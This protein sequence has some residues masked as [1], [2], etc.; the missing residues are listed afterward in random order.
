MILTVDNLSYKV[1][2]DNEVELVHFYQHRNEQEELIVPEIAARRRVVSISSKAFYECENLRR[3]VLPPTVKRIR[4]EAFGLCR[5]L[6]SINLP[7]SIETLEEGVFEGCVAL[8]HIVLPP[9]LKA[10][11]EGLFYESGIT[12]VRIPEGITEIPSGAFYDCRKLRRVVLPLTMQKVARDAFHYCPELAA[13]FAPSIDHIDMF[14]GEKEW[15]KETYPWFGDDLEANAHI[16]GTKNN[17]SELLKKGLECSNLQST[18]DLWQDLDM[19]AAEWNAYRW[20]AKTHKPITTKGASLWY[21]F[22]NNSKPDL[23]NIDDNKYELT[24]DTVTREEDFFYKWLVAI[25]QLVPELDVRF[26]I[27]SGATIDVIRGFADV[28][29]I[30]EEGTVYIDMDNV[31]VDFQSGVDKVDEATK[32]AYEGH[33]DDIPGIFALME[34]M[35]GAIEAVRKLTKQHDCYI[36][37]TAPWN[38]PS[39]W[40]DKLLWVKKYLGEL[41]YKRLIISHH[42]DLCHGDYL[43]DDSGWNGTSEFEGEWIIFGSPEYP[44]WESVVNYLLK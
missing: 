19:I 18:G 7:E 24:F 34:P 11:P 14:D 38:N 20:D 23:Y 12:D 31:L 8:H 9:M 35:P 3:V 37:T 21:F 10:I 27:C 28:D 39:A 25:K 1:L 40:S 17:L 32:R 30:K 26:D 33:L 13:V 2:N 4:R 29:G 16:I 44:D 22:L 41:F 36:L 43:I 6:E 15:M 42:K 5:K